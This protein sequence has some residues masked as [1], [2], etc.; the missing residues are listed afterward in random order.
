MT[1]VESRTNVGAETGAR[2][3]EGV[4]QLCT[5]VVLRSCQILVVLIEESRHRGGLRLF[6]AGCDEC[7]I[8]VDVARP[9]LITAMK[10]D[11]PHALAL[12]DIADY[13]RRPLVGSELLL[14]IVGI[15]VGRNVT[16]LPVVARRDG[17]CGQLVADAEVHG[18]VDIQIT[19]TLVARLYGII[20][21]VVVS[22]VLVCQ[23]TVGLCIVLQ[24][25]MA[26]GEF[27][28]ML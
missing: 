27:Q 7:A 21:F 18:I 16:L 9:F 5:N 3:E 8:A 14:A 13:R 20:V 25:F 24:F 4:L 19:P 11:V 26:E 15:E 2:K 6:V 23:L 22:A 17:P 1:V 28:G 10:G 12:Y